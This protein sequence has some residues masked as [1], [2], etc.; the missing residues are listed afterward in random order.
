[1]I[2]NGKIHTGKI[3]NGIRKRLMYMSLV[4]LLGLGLMAG[5][6]ARDGDS[7]ASPT[8]SS[9]DAS[10]PLLNSE[11]SASKEAVSE[12]PV[13]EEFD[14]EEWQRQM[15]AE[16]LEWYETLTEEDYVTAKSTEELMPDDWQAEQPFLVL[17][18]DLPE[19][20]TKIYGRKGGADLLILE[21]QG[22]R[23]AFY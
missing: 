10:E 17:L 12:E 6:G 5:C 15:E 19:A 13:S 4:G 1:M 8:E 11:E 2:Y 22:Q 21:H 23:R 18:G 9:E 14:F 7:A 3:H 16:A 20:E